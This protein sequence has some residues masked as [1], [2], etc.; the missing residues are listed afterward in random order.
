MAQ[1]RLMLQLCVL[2]EDIDD[3]ARADMARDLVIDDTEEPEEL[4]RLSDYCD[5]REIGEIIADFFEPGISTEMLAG[6]E[7][8][9]AFHSAQALHAEWRDETVEL[10]PIN[11]A[12]SGPVPIEPREG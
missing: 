6:S 2:V 9:V 8:Y 1:R 12:G 7:I 11:L 3:E 10:D 5:A 4:P